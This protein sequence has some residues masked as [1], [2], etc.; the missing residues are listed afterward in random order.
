MT[1][2]IVLLILVIII[3]Y[4]FEYI[5][6][7]HD[8]ANAISTVISTKA[9]SPRHAI[10]Y[11]A[12]LDF[13]GAFFGTHVA[14]TIGVGLVS[15][16][17]ITQLVILSA[18]LGAVIW[19]ILTWLWGLP[20]SSSHALIGGLLGA[21]MSRAMVHLHGQYELI[22]RFPSCKVEHPAVDVI[23]LHNVLD[24][25]L[26]PMICSP[27]LGFCV[28]FLVIWILL[29]IFY[30]VRP[31]VLNRVFRKMQLVSSGFLAFS[32]GSNDAQKTMG[33]ITLSLLTFGVIKETTFQ[34]PTWVICTCALMLSMGTMTGGWKIIRTMS[35][36][37]IKMKP[38]HGFSVEMASA[39]IILTASHFGFP[40]STTHIISTAIVGVGSMVKASAVKWGI[41]KNI[42]TAWV[43]TI[44]VCMCLSA[45]IY[46][47]LSMTALGAN[48][49]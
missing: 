32:H 47:C 20:S 36:K 37:V 46:K 29:R 23:N 1:V 45:L 31:E 27:I 14:Q 13:T 16:E 43:C 6:G 18:L 28:G 48:G 44:P 21:A 35:S 10:L 39:S 25:I 19:N 12:C 34:I 38:I 22:F 40:V 41:V 4:L 33:I 49:G 8:S 7:F 26:L 17:S 24:K 30:R 9:L 15:G 11:A 5:N 42:V 3:A 2:A